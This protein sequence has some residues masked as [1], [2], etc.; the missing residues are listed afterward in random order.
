M[1]KMLML[2]GL[3]TAGLFTSCNSDSDDV[4]GLGVGKISAK[5]GTYTYDT[6]NPLY[7]AAIKYQG[8]ML[9]VTTNETYNLNMR[10]D[11]YNGVGTY[12]ATNG[13]PADTY[14]SFTTN[15]LDTTIAPIPNMSSSHEGGEIT[16]NVTAAN[17]TSLEGTFSGKI[18]TAS[19][20]DL[21]D[22]T[23]GYFLAKIEVLQAPQ[24]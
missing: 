1:K 21:V 3:L 12:T 22:V 18:R 4:S 23:N 8:D 17:S 13:A 16:I 24:N 10:L 7:V 2:A 9:L 11:D 20:A 6:N 15:I 14:L 5:I 19:H